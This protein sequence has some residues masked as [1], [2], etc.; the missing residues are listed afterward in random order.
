MNE[1]NYLAQSEEEQQALGARLAEIWQASPAVVHLQGDLGSGKT[2]LVR[3]YL[4]GQGYSGAVRSPTYTLVEPY[5]LPRI[6]VFHFDLYRLCDPEELE[7]LGAREMFDGKAQVFIE[8]P[9]R[10]EGWLPSPDIVVD[11]QM[12]ADGRLLSL[13]ARS[14]RGE[15][16]LNAWRQA[17]QNTHP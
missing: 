16:L 5:E 8:W 4:R 11:I 15:S 17:E 6:S 3:G 1:I 2:T 14:E 13:S 10:G 12:R 7:F 9:G